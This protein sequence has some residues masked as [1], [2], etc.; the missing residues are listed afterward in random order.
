MRSPPTLVPY[1]YKAL[2]AAH[3]TVHQTEGRFNFNGVQTDMALEKMY[4]IKTKLFTGISQRP[5]AV[6]K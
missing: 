1:I 4:N 3:F 2:K 5:A 6:G